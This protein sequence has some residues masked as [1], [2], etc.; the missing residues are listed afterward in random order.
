MQEVL[1]CPRRPNKQP[2][3]FATVLRLSSVMCP[4]CVLRVPE[5]EPSRFAA[6]TVPDH[7]KMELLRRIRKFLR[8]LIAPI[9][10]R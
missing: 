6:D 2:F 1:P 3:A 7:V 8:E 4:S 10:S 9:S 5:M